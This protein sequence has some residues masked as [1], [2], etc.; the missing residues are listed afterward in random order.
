MSEDINKKII[1]IFKNHKKGEESNNP[2]VKFFAGFNY[3]KLDKDV[4]G[5]AFS[6]KHLLDYAKQCNYIVRVMR[7]AQGKVFLYNYMVSSEKLIEF[8]SKFDKNEL[9]GKI[10][11]IDKYTPETLA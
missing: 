4:N 8:A 3:V 5:H 10:I 11:E 6:A 9:D 1:S 2:K 7:E